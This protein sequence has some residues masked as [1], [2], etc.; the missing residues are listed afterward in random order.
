MK[1]VLKNFVNWVLRLVGLEMRSVYSAGHMFSE[2]FQLLK[3]ILP[4][5]PYTVIDVGV[6]EGT[7]ELYAAFPHT[8]HRYLLI[9]ASP[10]YRDVVLRLGASMGAVVENVFCGSH[11]G[12][13]DFIPRTESAAAK[14]SKYS[15]K[16]ERS[17]DRV[18]VASAT[19][20]SLLGTHHLPGPY[21]LKI[22]VEGAELDVLFGAKNT[23]DFVEAIIIETP[24][25]LRMSGS[26]SFGD[27]VTVLTER[28][29]A[30]FDI[31]EMS[32]NSRN[33]FLNL[34]NGIFI[35]KNNPL[36]ERALKPADQK[37]RPS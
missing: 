13:E 8:K 7:P 6:A 26:S 9:E 25:M 12:R 37:L 29:F 3:T 18:S 21:I 16:S 1:N 11:N 35:K 30:L 4:D 24:I 20:D 23:L 15:R 14:G 33:R 36:W 31:A 22:D 34:A 32:Y 10:L 19:L 2:S 28:G 27:I 17:P 5:T